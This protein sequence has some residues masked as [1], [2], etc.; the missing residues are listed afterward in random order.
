MVPG[1][2]SSQQ[3]LIIKTDDAG[4]TNHI[5]RLTAVKAVERSTDYNLT[6]GDRGEDL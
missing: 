5:L 2:L 1:L 6:L 3:L 4:S